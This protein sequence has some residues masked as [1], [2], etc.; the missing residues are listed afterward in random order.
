MFNQH[1]TG[2]TQGNEVRQAISPFVVAFK[3]SIGN[4]VMNIYAHGP[5]FSLAAS[6]TAKIISFKRLAALVKPIRAASRVCSAALVIVIALAF[7]T[8]TIVSIS[9]FS[10]TKSASAHLKVGFQQRI[11]FAALFAFAL[12][13]FRIDMRLGLARSKFRPALTGTKAIGARYPIL[14]GI[15][16]PFADIGLPFFGIMSRFDSMLE[17]ALWAAIF[18][19]LAFAEFKFRSTSRADSRFSMSFSVISFPAVTRAIFSARMFGV[20]KNSAALWAYL[21]TYHRIGSYRSYLRG[22]GQAVGRAVR[23][24]H[25]AALA[26]ALI[27]P[28]RYAE[29]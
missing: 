4:D 21:R 14:K 23:A 12:N 16:A 25:E 1:V 8:L 27:I 18:L 7:H 2:A 11:G 6:L 9:A 10:R 5:G 19:L 28:Q 13:V 26:H 22:C 29:A 17:S 24:V 15:A 3:C 20:R